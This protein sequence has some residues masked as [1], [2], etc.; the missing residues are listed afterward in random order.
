VPRVS[1]IIP[2]FNCGRFVGRAIDSVL[3]QTYRDYEIVVAD[4]GSTDDTR[5][6][7][8]KYGPSVR[9]VY[10]A[11]RGVS[12][13]R[14]RALALAG[15]ELVAYLD[16]DDMWY[17][18][19]LERQVAF[20]DAHPECGLVH[21][22]IAVIDEADSVIHPRFNRRD[23][24]RI[25][26]QGYC[27][28]DLLRRSHVQT[29]TVMER[30][31]CLDANG[32]FD[33]RIHGVEDYYQWILVAMSGKA[34]G[35]IDEPLAMYRWR[36]GSL[37]SSPRR[38]FEELIKM[39]GILMREQSVAQRFGQAAVD[40]VRLRVLA[41]ERE[42]AYLDRVEGRPDLARRRLVRLI[43]QEPLRRELYVEFVKASIPKSVGVRLKT[44]KE[45]WF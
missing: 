41:L 4:D 12:A 42:I 28:L 18:P 37:S 21:S 6:V 14:N 33:E 10:Q 24:S 8:E 17:P 31:E 29:P 25:P 43:G 44:L 13:A 3:V 19:K 27:V 9:Y 26:P 11:N 40:C 45:Q 30:R 20:L 34:V 7:V 22:D 2:A 5:L 39:F 15:G 38:Q 35:Y 1:V 16:S 32:M 36:D 23:G